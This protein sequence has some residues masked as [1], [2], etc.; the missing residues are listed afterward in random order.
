MD[1]DRKVDLPKLLNL[2]D[3]EQLPHNYDF[4]VT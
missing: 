4:L 3:L 2:N 1:E